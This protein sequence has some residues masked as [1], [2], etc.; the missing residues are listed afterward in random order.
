[1]HQKVFPLLA[2]KRPEY[3]E[4]ITQFT[5][6]SGC[7]IYQGG[8]WPRRYQNSAFICEP[9]VHT[10]HEDMITPVV[11]EGAGKSIGYEAIKAQKNEFLAGTDLWFRPITARY[12]P[13]GA[14]YLLEF[15]T[16]VG[17]HSHVAGAE[18]ATRP[19]QDYAHGRI[20]RIQHKHPQKFETPQLA[21]AP[22]TNLVKA[23][24][25][26]NA[27]VRMTAQRLLVERGETN[28]TKA[29]SLLIASNRVA[30]VRVQA[31]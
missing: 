22:A 13:D 31:L 29:L 30:Y 20:W 15:Y 4:G 26:P 16:P 8:V 27:W 25:H 2:D 23:L 18:A 6:A 21:D 11:E 7:M 19:D 5:N 10:D 1:D 17:F 9:T 3:A 12:G 14:M 28:V 24:E